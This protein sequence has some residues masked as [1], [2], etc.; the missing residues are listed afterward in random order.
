MQF[1]TITTSD[2]DKLRNLQPQDWADIIP[3]IEYY[4]K[5]SICNPMKAIVNDTVAGTGTS[6]VFDKTAWI[7]HIIV[8]REFRNKGIGYKIVS[9]LIENLKSKSIETCSLIATDLGKPLYLKTGFRIVGEYSFLQREKP[10][11]NYPVSE[12]II[13]YTDEYRNEIYELDKK[14]SGESREKLLT[15]FLANSLLYV[16]KNKLL[17]YYL[18]NL[19]EGLIFADSD[20]AGLE[21][22]KLKYSRVD[23]AV[24]PSDNTVG[25][26]FLI[27]NGFVETKKASRMIYGKD[28]DWIPTKVFNRI[29]GNLG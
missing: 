11:E 20:E 13:S 3:D 27:Q 6:I 2:L 25:I 29:G 9:N 15:D 26:K 18:P 1:E 5:S 22:M 17:G 8:D 12:N 16:E 24:L 28:I 21:L 4:I 23:K 19:K 7:A 10:W 14:I